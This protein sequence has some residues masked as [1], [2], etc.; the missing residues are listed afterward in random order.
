MYVIKYDDGIYSGIYSDENGDYCYSSN[1]LNQCKPKVFK[2]LKG[3]E[4]HLISLKDKIPFGND[5]EAYNF[6]ILEWT[7][8]DLEKH[9]EYIGIKYI[10]QIKKQD[11]KLE[12]YWKK[13]F[14]PLKNSKIYIVSIK[15]DNNICTIR[16]LMPYCTNT[17]EYFFQ[18]DLNKNLVIDGF[19][20]KVEKSANEMINIIRECS[21]INDLWK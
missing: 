20:K 11:T 19:C 17:E 18:A 8:N 1:K 10:P 5:Y 7:N 12:K 6:K 14:K 9:L 16:Y 3:A 4:N 2:T 15:I 13:V 21:K